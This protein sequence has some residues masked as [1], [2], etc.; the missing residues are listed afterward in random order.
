MASLVTPCAVAPPLSASFFHGFTHWGAASVGNLMRP[1]SASQSGLF[2]AAELPTPASLPPLAPRSARSGPALTPVVPR[3]AAIAP[4]SARKARFGPRIGY[5]RK[6]V[7]V[8]DF[9]GLSMNG[10]EGASHPVVVQFHGPVIPGV[11][12]HGDAHRHPCRRPDDQLSRRRSRPHVR[13]PAA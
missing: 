11:A 8:R 4:T 2:S 3:V 6:H 5:P 13:L 1:V 9:D 10:S 7:F 12:D